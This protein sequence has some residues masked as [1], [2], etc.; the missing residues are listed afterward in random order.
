MKYLFQLDTLFATL[1][2]FFVIFG[3]ASLPFEFDAVDPI[4]DA[5]QDFETTD[6]V[7]NQLVDYEEVPVDPNIVLV[8]IGEV[9][10]A[11][12]AKQIEILNRYQ[13]KVMAMDIR[14][15]KDKTPDQ[16][17]PLMMAFSQVQ[18]L[19]LGSRL[20]DTD[21]L[22]DLTWHSME[23]S[24]PKFTQYG[25]NAFVNLHTGDENGGGFRTS[26]MFI[27]RA[28]LNDS[29]MLS[30]PAKIVQLFD[31]TKFNVLMKRTNATEII[32][33]HGNIFP[34]D[35]PKSKFM[36]LDVNDVL[37][38][39]FD[40][41]MIKD[42][43]LIFGFLGR[44]IRDEFHIEDKFYTPLNEQMAGRAYPDMYGAVVHANVISM[45]LNERYINYFPNVVNALIAFIL[46]Y[47]NVAL[48]LFI[49]DK[50]KV[51]YDLI[52]K[53]WQLIESIILMTIV[54]VL[55]YNY[56]LKIEFTF[57]LIAILLSGDLTELYA[58]SVRDLFLRGLKRLGLT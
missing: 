49:S 1:F 10:R 39:N 30:F 18:N 5:L 19:V 14:F 12:I 40:G 3:V 51:Y 8:N 29:T 17:F 54:I 21:T 22:K 25:T 24:N 6:I 55:M 47:L 20:Y 56:N 50:A 16:D 31:S 27:P 52:T 2:I 53:A 7:F 42:K 33:W 57:A 37:N 11:T 13:P 36:A 28:K 35:L 9:N 15:I 46:T 48:F 34:D 26:R 44:N 38:E 58:G 41:S 4:A 23:T 45:I 32:N 43:I